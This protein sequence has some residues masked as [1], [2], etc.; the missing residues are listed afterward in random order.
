MPSPYVASCKQ[1]LWAGLGTGLGLGDVH[2]PSHLLTWL[3]PFPFRLRQ[4]EVTEAA[5]NAGI[6]IVGGEDLI[7]KARMH[8]VVL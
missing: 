2:L 3:P 7:S 8:A 4:E 5:R 1:V 6:D